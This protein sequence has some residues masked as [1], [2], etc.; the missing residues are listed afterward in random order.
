M[1]LKL[2]YMQMVSSKQQNFKTAAYLRT[3]FWKSTNIYNYESTDHIFCL[4]E[5]N[6][7][8]ASKS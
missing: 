8:A 5:N 1:S 3:V 4:Q 2:G 7:H 6:V